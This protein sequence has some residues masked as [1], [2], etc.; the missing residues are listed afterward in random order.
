MVTVVVVT[1]GWLRERCVVHYQPNS[2]FSVSSLATV[3][4]LVIRFAHETR[5]PL[6]P[7][8]VKV[9]W[10]RERCYTILYYNILYYNIL[11]NLLYSILYSILYSTLLY[12]L[13]YS[14]L[15]YST[16]LYSTL[17]YYTIVRSCPRGC[18][19]GE[20]FGRVPM[21]RGKDRAI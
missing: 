7:Q 11:Y 18:I 16:L 12:T 2:F 10:L 8:V 17:L 21:F 5:C 20:L 4:P 3:M 1:V 6:L 19:L 14:T 13:L 15:L 9:G